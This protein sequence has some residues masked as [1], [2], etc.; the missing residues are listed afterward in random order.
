MQLQCSKCKT[1]CV[2]KRRPKDGELFGAVCDECHAEICKICAG[3]G[4]SDCDSLIATSRKLLF[5]CSE[6]RSTTQELKKENENL[7]KI[8][9]EKDKYSQSIEKKCKEKDDKIFLLTNQVDDL[10][11]QLA[12]EVD[13]LNEEIVKKDN[14]IKRLK[15]N[16]C[17]FELELLECEKSFEAEVSD[18]KNIVSELKKKVEKI[19]EENKKLLLENTQRVEMV[20]QKN[21]SETDDLKNRIKELMDERSVNKDKLLIVKKELLEVKRMEEKLMCGLKKN[22]DLLSDEKLRNED[23]SIK[24]SASEV[25]LNECLSSVETKD[26]TMVGLKNQLQELMEVNKNM[27]GTI[28][29]LEEENERYQKELEQVRYD[30]SKDYPGKSDMTTKVNNGLHHNE[31]LNFNENINNILNNDLNKNRNDTI[32]NNNL[33]KLAK[34]RQ[35]L[36]LT[37]EYGKYLL[38]FLES[39]L[40]ADFHVQVI[41]K[42]G[43]TFKNVIRGQEAAI[44]ALKKDDF[45]IVLAGLNNNDISLNDITL[46]ANWCFFT[47]LILCTIPAKFE[48]SI[49][50]NN[51]EY[52][53]AK[54]IK[55]VHN[56][57]QFS[58]NVNILDLQTKFSYSDYTRSF[59]LN[60]KGLTKMAYLMSNLICNFNGAPSGFL[61]QIPLVYL[62]TNNTDSDSL[63]KDFT[64]VECL[65]SVNSNNNHSYSI[66]DNNSNVYEHTP[67]R[68]ELVYV[69]KPYQM[70]RR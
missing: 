39:R 70:V 68:E 51:I 34:S 33:N 4:S 3:F 45:V 49:P 18:Q 62:R 63:K 2:F 19:K 23:L 17:D 30:F 38:P 22:M 31:I 16:T 52:V 66:I 10:G 20:I 24:L 69:K 1:Q 8:V 12:K 28:R 26:Q 48:E 13:K 43:A 59:F 41:C 60:N 67:A 40:S 65:D 21:I 42:P 55:S 7:N 29:L 56:I 47:N 6:Y 25:N 9:I 50:N 57:R 64:N 5:R 54:I 53:N 35:I 15:R 58:N 14:H 44:S 61:R 11:E 46:I 36:L 37:D 27:V 32:S